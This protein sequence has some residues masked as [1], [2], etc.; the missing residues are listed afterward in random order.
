[1]YGWARCPVHE[2]VVDPGTVNCVEGEVVSEGEVTKRP[3]KAAN[4]RLAG[5]LPVDDGYVRLVVD[6]EYDVLIAQIGAVLGNRGDG[7]EHFAPGDV[8]AALLTSCVAVDGRPDSG[9]NVAGPH[10]TMKT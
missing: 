7:A 3:Q 6:N 9:S 4:P 8:A 2:F 10:T 5:P 1:V